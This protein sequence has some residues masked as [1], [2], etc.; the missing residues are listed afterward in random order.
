MVQGSVTRMAG[1]IDNVMD[2]ARGRLG[3]GLTLDR[4]AAQPVEPMLRQV[5]AELQSNAPD[6]VIE[7][8]FALT[9]PVNCDRRRIGQLASNLLGNALTYGAADNRSG[10]VR[11][12]WTAGSSF[13]SPM[14]VSLFP[15]RAGRPL[16]ALLARDASPQPARRGA[17]PVYLSRN[18]RGSWR[19]ARCRIHA[20]GNPLYVP[21]AVEPLTA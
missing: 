1:L 4:D 16:P 2:F 17:G 15:R 6:R 13:S 21:D 12:R 8:R 5:V 20:G 14:P 9:A 3:G 7:A 18:Y 11:R 19:Q 10:W